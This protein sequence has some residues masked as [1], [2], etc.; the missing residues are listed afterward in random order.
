M[1]ACT[2]SWSDPIFRRRIKIDRDQI[3]YS[4]KR[5]PTCLLP[6]S[7]NRVCYLELMR[8]EINTSSRVYSPIAVNSDV[9]ILV[10]DQTVSWHLTET[11]CLREHNSMIP[12][13]LCPVIVYSLSI[14]DQSNMLGT[15]HAGEITW[16]RSKHDP[17]KWPGWISQVWPARRQCR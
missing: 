14:V 11:Q 10:V 6:S 9:H 4:H 2:L 17:I 3:G 5:V 16:H 15:V 8:G 12:I 7:I 13:L 1:E